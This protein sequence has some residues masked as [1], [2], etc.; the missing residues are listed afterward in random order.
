[1]KYKNTQKN[2]QKNIQ[3]IQR[4]FEDSS[5]TARIINAPRLNSKFKR[6]RADFLNAVYFRLGLT[7]TLGFANNLIDGGQPRAKNVF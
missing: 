4:P 2:I 5:L 1:M 3:K 6:F 7:G